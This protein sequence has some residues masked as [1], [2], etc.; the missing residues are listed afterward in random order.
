MPN[1]EGFPSEMYI[2]LF[3]GRVQ[4]NGPGKSMVQASFSAKMSRCAPTCTVRTVCDFHIHQTFWHNDMNP[5]GLHCITDP[6]NAVVALRFQ[7]SMLLRTMCSLHWKESVGTVLCQLLQVFPNHCVYEEQSLRHA[8]WW[9][10]ASLN[11]ISPKLVYCPDPWA[12][13]SLVILV[14]V[15]YSKVSYSL[16]LYCTFLDWKSAGKSDILLQLL[17]YKR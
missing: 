1:P 3:S 8:F 14:S 7:Y 2:N 16:S 4:E 15:T 12:F 13:F 5:C 10:L 11:R 6:P 9:L 17:V